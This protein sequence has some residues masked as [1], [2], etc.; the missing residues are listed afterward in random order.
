MKIKTNTTSRVRDKKFREKER[1]CYLLLSPQI[2]GFLVFSIIPMLWA[3]SLS[4]TYYD[5]IKTRFVGWENFLLLFHDSNYWRAVVTTL[6][7]AV[8]KIPV[9]LPLALILAVLLSRKIKG[10]GFYRAVYY[11]PHV[12]S[13]ALVA[14]VFSNIFSFFGVFNAL[15]QKTGLM[16]IPVDWFAEKMSAMWIIVIA[17]IWKTFGVNVLYFIAA[18]ANIPEDVYESARL[19]GATRLQTFFRITLPMIAPTLQIII[20]L[21]L[22]GTLG[23]SEMVLVLTNGAPGGLTYTVNAYIF[24]NYAPGITNGTVNV[25]YGCAMSLVTGLMLSVITLGYMKMSSGVKEVY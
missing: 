2:I 21:S 20:M 4:W 1:M 11:L 16:S 8:M 3:I 15:M 10:A 5:T 12:I 13:T 25:G 19:D 17:D 9:E 7:F 24:N 14:L 6:Q 22:I 18:L 23:T